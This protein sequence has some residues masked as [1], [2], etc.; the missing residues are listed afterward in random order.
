MEAPTLEEY[1]RNLRTVVL[2]WPVGSTHEY[3]SCNY[4]VLGLIIEMVSGQSFE[5][6]MQ[7]H[8]FAPLHMPHSFASEQPAKQAGLAQG[9]QW[10]FGL[11]VP[12][13]SPYNPSNV[14]GGYLISSVEDMSHLL[15]AELNGGRFGGGNV[16]SADGV[17]T[18][19]RP[20][21]PTGHADG[22]SYGMGWVSGPVG[23]VPV[24]Y[25]NGA[26]FN[27]HALLLIEPQNRWGV[28]LLTNSNSMLATAAS[29]QV[30]EAGIVDQLVGQSVPAAGM[31]LTTIYLIL[32]GGL[33]L[34]SV[35]VLWRLLRLRRWDPVHGQT[36]P[37][38]RWVRDV[39]LPLL[40][41]WGVPLAFVA[42]IWPWLGDQLGSD[43]VTAMRVFLDIGWWLMIMGALLVLAGAIRM[44]L[45]FRA[46]RHMAAMRSIRPSP[47]AS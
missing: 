34:L 38:I 31:S 17:A 27:S 46:W 25:H 15:I 4:R 10:V 29:F 41:D 11:P 8:V 6:Y 47:S 14:P 26:G 36:L 18:M 23:G 20:G 30:L 39:A 13:N 19:Q 40:V 42:I 21:V 22:S 37:R 45:V 43:W 7:E 16:V 12:T 9:Y 2:K 1:T 35:F 5:R 3:C 44:W 33:L 24:I 32:D 28:V